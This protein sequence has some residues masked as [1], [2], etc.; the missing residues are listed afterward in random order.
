MSEERENREDQSKNPLE[1][2]IVILGAGIT[3]FTVGYLLIEISTGRES[4][5]EL[6]VATGDESLEKGTYLVPVEI[7]N[8]GGA[9]AADAVV[10]VCNGSAEC[11][12]LTFKYVPRASKRSG[13]V[14]FSKPIGSPSVRV[15]GYRI[16]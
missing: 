12:E 4:N 16:P 6:S 13:Y 8:H 14:G 15:M 10:E 2:I 3:L 11:A 1:W 7:E 9:A 5:P